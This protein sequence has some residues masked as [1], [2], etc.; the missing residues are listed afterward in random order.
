MP[1]GGME[2]PCMLTFQGR[3]NLVEKTRNTITKLKIG[4]PTLL[5]ATGS[6][7]AINIDVTGSSNTSVK[8]LTELSSPGQPKVCVNAKVIES[9]EVTVKTEVSLPEHIPILHMNTEVK[10][11]TQVAINTCVATVPMN[12]SFQKQSVEVLNVDNNQED[13]Q[14]KELWVRFGKLSLMRVQRNEIELGH[15]LKDYHINFAQAI[16]KDQFSIEGLQCTLLQKTHQTLN[17]R[18]QIIHSRGNH[19]IVACVLFS[20]VG[21]VNVYDSLYDTL[22]DETIVVIKYLF[23]NENINIKMIKVQK[24][25]GYD[26][27]GLFAIANTVQLAKKYVAKTEA[28]ANKCDPG[29]VKYQQSV[30]RSHLVNCFEKTKMTGF[31]LQH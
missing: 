7:P 4:M 6:T 30:M 3:K 16:I 1:Q 21:S 27:C 11:S 10:D 2:V 26:D 14:T 18:L 23:N 12:N 19:W 9:S 8:T 20:E 31:P 28:F 25:K 15:R 29:M 5:K 24:Q 13:E 22:D 17:N